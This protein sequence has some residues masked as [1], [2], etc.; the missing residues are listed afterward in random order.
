[1]SDF[2]FRLRI[3]LAAR[4]VLAVDTS[5]AVLGHGPDGQEVLLSSGSSE[6]NIANAKVLYLLSSGWPS[7]D[8]AA[9][10]G[11]Q[12]VDALRMTFAALRVGVDMSD[13][14]PSPGGASPYLIEKMYDE[15]GARVLNESRGLMVYESEPQPLFFSTS[16]SGALSVHCD[17]FQEVVAVA[18]AE[19][20]A[21][22]PAHVV[23]IELFNASFFQSSADT[24]LLVLVMAVEAMVSSALRSQ[25]A[26]DYLERL[27]E[28]TGHEATLDAKERDV[29]SQAMLRLKRESIGQAARS[30]I[31]ERLGERMYGDMPAA[32]FFDRCY[33]LRS[34]LA[35]AN[36]P[37][38]D[39]QLV[40]VSVAQLEVMVADLIAGGALG[41]I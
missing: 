7:E 12:Y 23:A 19:G 34:R 22:P 15:H 32:Q 2:T 11:S 36:H 6:R 4:S 21:P 26:Q 29:L 16:A 18:L 39:H 17:R 38:P 27:A 25:Q 30:L 31:R 20:L 10:A 13:R 5:Q 40:G 14:G 37:L 28:Q 24:R 3:Q 8:D 35:H 33:N 41:V 9:E 1:M